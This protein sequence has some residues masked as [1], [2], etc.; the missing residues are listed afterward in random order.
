[1]TAAAS[2]SA[3]GLSGAIGFFGFK[4][5]AR[6]IRSCPKSGSS[7]G[8]TSASNAEMVRSRRYAREVADGVLR[9]VYYKSQL[10]LRNTH[11]NIVVVVDSI[12]RGFKARVSLPLL[13][14]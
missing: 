13:L 12:A 10:L 7:G 6:S 1:M 4:K 8:S 2:A 3:A 9:P 5:L 14:R 11:G